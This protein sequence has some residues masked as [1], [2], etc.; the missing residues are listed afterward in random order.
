MVTTETLGTATVISHLDERNALAEEVIARYAIRH[1]KLDGSTGFAA[2]LSPIPFTGAA[3]LAGQ[4]YYQFAHTYP[5][6]TQELAAIYNASPDQWTKRTAGK[7]L[8]AEGVA[9]ALVQAMVGEVAIHVGADVGSQVGADFFQEVAWDLFREGGAG[10]AASQIPFVGAFFG[11]AADV[12]LAVTM[13]WRV[14]G[15]VAVHFINGGWVNG[16]RKETY[17]AVKS[18][19]KLS[20]ETRRRVLPDL[21]RAI[22]E[23]LERLVEY[24]VSQIKLMMRFTSERARIREELIRTDGPGAPAIPSDI[25]DEAIKRVSGLT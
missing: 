1:A 5:Q 18:V 17:K 14:G 2:G 9:E 8:A 6:M 21:R 15:L 4:L 23:V 12:L 11:G 24:T 22:P 7:Y 10:V 20:P 16:S 13:T 3:V 25:V 19:V